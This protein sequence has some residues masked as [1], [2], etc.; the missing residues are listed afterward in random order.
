MDFIIINVANVLSV[1]FSH[2][3]GQIIQHRLKQICC[4]HKF[5]WPNCS[6]LCYYLAL[7]Y[8]YKAGEALAID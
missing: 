8:W 3:L 1:I 2:F 7:K 4:K 5:M 6:N